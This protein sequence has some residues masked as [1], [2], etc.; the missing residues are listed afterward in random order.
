MLNILILELSFLVKKRLEDTLTTFLLLPNQLTKNLTHFVS[1]QYILTDLIMNIFIY[2]YIS[3]NMY[4]CINQN[5]LLLICAIFS[6]SF[7][8]DPVDPIDAIEPTVTYL[9]FSFNKEQ[10]DLPPLS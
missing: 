5:I 1:N 10:L 8:T 7:L 3:Y 9:L 4:I 6:F 2:L